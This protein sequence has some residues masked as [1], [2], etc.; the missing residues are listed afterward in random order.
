MAALD[1]YDGIFFRVLRKWMR[2]QSSDSV[3]TDL[4]IVSARFGL[5]DA[6]KQIP[7]YDVRM[8]RERASELAPQIQAALRIRLR[9]NVYRN[10]FVNLGREYLA[11]VAGLNGLQR[12]T[13]AVGGIGQR[14]RQMK[15]WLETL[16]EA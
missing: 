15:Q 10:I 3:P 11:T 16:P 6:N 14:A 4:L 13:W 9:R 2:A 7:N 8:T 1:R 5:I 12:A